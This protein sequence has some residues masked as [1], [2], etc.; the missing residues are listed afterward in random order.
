LDKD[1]VYGTAKVVEGKVKVAIGR[2]TGNAKLVAQGE[3]E[4]REGEMQNTVGGIRD[5]IR[6]E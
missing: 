1:R 5:A 3:A 6:D 2:A 4:Q